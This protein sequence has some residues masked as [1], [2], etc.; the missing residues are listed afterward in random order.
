MALE[1][2]ADQLFELRNV[3]DLLTG[4]PGVEVTPSVFR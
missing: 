3:A 1:E 2:S 4:T